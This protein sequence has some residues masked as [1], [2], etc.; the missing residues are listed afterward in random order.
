MHPEHRRHK[1]EIPPEVNRELYKDFMKLWRG[2]RTDWEKETQ[3]ALDKHRR[4]V[5][6]LGL[7]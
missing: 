4:A 7:K 5:E 6:A 3:K 2:P 1:I